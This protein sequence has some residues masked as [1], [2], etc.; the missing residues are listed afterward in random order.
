SLHRL[1]VANDVDAVL[2]GIDLDE[3]GVIGKGDRRQPDLKR[4]LAALLHR[5]MRGV[6]GP[7]GMNVV[8]GDLRHAIAGVSSATRS[9]SWDWPGAPL[10]LSRPWGCPAPAS[11]PLCSR[12]RPSGCGDSPPGRS[13]PA[14]TGA[15]PARF[16]ARLRL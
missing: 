8:V 4:L 11:S 5:S 16:G 14:R 2:A 1:E 9:R 12:R 6:I 15:S 13:P 3:V 10:S 7:F